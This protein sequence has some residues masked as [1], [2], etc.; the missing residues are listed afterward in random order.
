MPK[1]SEVPKVRNFVGTSK[2]VFVAANREGRDLGP[3]GE[4]LASLVADVEDSMGDTA[5]G[6]KFSGRA[7]QEILE[8]WTWAAEALIE[9]KAAHYLSDEEW[10]RLA[11]LY[12]NAPVAS[13]RRG[14]EW[15]DGLAGSGS[16]RKK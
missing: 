15:V 7:L 11:G 9:R 5:I 3:W 2:A 12:K 10:D 8:W 14:H 6:P 16:G 1:K 4:L 13:T